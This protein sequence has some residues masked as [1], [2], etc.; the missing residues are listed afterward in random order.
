MQ[1]HLFSYSFCG[2]GFQHNLG[3]SSGDSHWCSQGD[4]WGCSHLMIIWGESFFML[5]YKAVAVALR[6]Q[7]SLLLPRVHSLSCGSLHRAAHRYQYAAFF[8]EAREKRQRES[9]WKFVF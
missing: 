3:G 5:I 4:I 7:C 8:F 9:K 6:L 1:Q 2:S